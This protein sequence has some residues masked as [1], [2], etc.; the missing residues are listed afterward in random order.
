[1]PL[2][3]P[4]DSVALQTEEVMEDLKA[5]LEEAGASFDTVVMT[6]VYLT[7][8]ASWSEFNEAYKQYF[9]DRLRPT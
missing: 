9:D 7:D 3:A 4:R 2:S 1:M 8:F 6:N 5:T